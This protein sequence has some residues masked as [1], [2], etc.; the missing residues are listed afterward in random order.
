MI[1]CEP[2]G[3]AKTDEKSHLVGWNSLLGLALV[4]DESIAGE[5]SQPFWRVHSP[6]IGGSNPPSAMNAEAH[7]IMCSWPGMLVTDDG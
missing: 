4:N 5:D 1:C 6:Q 2:V 7:R 3:L